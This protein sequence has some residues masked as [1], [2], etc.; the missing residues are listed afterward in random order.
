MN[1]EL[2]GRLLEWKCRAYVK[3]VDGGQFFNAIPASKTDSTNVF[4]FSTD[5]GKT[6]TSI[7]WHNVSLVTISYVQAEAN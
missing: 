4:S 6:L 2:F 1:S 3:L 7:P 5:D